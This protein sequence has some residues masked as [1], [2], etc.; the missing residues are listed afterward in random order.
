MVGRQQWKW[1]RQWSCAGRG[2]GRRGLGELVLCLM[3]LALCLMPL[4]LCLVPLAQADAQQR[5]RYVNDQ[6]VVVLDQSIPARFVDRG[7]TILGGDGH[8]IKVV[9]SVTERKRQEEQ[10]KVVDAEHKRQERINQSDQELLRRW[11][12]KQDRAEP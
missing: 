8:V 12:E 11:A 3:P 6:G 10:Q 2:A 7:Y 9:A 4:V 1:R 5:Y